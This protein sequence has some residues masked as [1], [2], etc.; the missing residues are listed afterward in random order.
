MDVNEVCLEKTGYERDEIVGKTV[1]DLK[2]SHVNDRAKYVTQ[3]LNHGKISNFE[4][5]FRMKSGELRDGL[6][7]GEVIELGG[8]KYILNVVNDITERKRVEEEL[9]ENQVRLQTVVSNVPVVLFC[10][11]TEG[12]FTFSE[13]RGLRTLGLRPGEVIFGKSVFEMYKDF[14]TVV[15]TK[16]GFKK[17]RN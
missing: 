2:W 15:N 6:I 13:G 9:L 12:I 17:R 7:S 16:R 5:R 8:E 1:I 11:D 14:P 3:L 4:T 10:I